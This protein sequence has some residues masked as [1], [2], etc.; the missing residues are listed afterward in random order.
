MLMVMSGTGSSMN[1]PRNATGRPTHTQS[2]TLRR[3]NRVRMTSTSKPPIHIF[4]I[5]MSM[6]PSRISDESNQVVKVTPSGSV[7]CRAAT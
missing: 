2:A 7:S 4:P 1:A 3:K 6:R 5:I